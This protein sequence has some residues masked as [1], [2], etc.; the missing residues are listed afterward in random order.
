MPTLTISCEI[1]FYQRELSERLFKVGNEINVAAHSS[2]AECFIKI[3]LYRTPHLQHYHYL[4]VDHRE[5]QF[6]SQ[7]VTGLQV[8]WRSSL[9]AHKSTI[10]V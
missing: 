9:M 3:Y 10:I 2:S 6:V 1:L 7:N 4:C 5:E 8:R